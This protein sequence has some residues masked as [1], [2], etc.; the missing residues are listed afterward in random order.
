MSDLGGGGEGRALCVALLPARPWATL[1]SRRAPTPRL[2]TFA[3]R[4][5]SETRSYL[6]DGKGALI[7]LFLSEM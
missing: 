3:P 6:G 5:A 4:R 2:Q 7:S 1:G